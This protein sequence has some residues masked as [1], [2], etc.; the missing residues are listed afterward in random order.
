[1]AGN[2]IAFDF[3]EN[4]MHVEIPEYDMQSGRR[5]VEEEEEEEEEEEDA[6]KFRFQCLSRSLFHIDTVAITPQKYLKTYRSSKIGHVKKSLKNVPLMEQQDLVKFE[7]I[8]R[9]GKI[10]FKVAQ[11]GSSLQRFRKFPHFF[12][13]YYSYRNHHLAANTWYVT[14]L[15]TAHCDQTNISVVKPMALKKKKKKKKKKKEEEKKKKEKKKK[16]KKKKMMKK[17]KKK[18]KKKEEEKKKKEKKK[19]KKKKKMMKKMK[20]KK[21]K[22]KLKKT[23]KRKKEKEVKKKKKEKKKEERKRAKE[24]RREGEDESNAYLRRGYQPP[25]C[26]FVAGLDFCQGVLQKNSIYRSVSLM[27]PTL[28]CCYSHLATAARNVY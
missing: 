1:M 24:E 11:G 3:R 18:K 12:I 4:E 10:D 23:K 6:L 15:A 17:K 25:I 26:R 16:K 8:R 22:K 27:L 14:A 13:E 7:V 28:R 9:K 19:K 5:E 21:K 2:C 20:K